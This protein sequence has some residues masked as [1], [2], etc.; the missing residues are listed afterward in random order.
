MLEIKIDLVPY[1]CQDM[2]KRIGFLRIW[3]DGT[4]TY[5]NGNYG[6][7]V[8]DEF[9]ETIAAGEFKNF[10]RDKGVFS[11]VKEILNNAI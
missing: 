9:K 7:E 1:G 5:K 2:R 4:G 8:I 11:L 3:N 6:Y 10:G